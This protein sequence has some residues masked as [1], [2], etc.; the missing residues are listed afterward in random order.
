[1]KGGLAMLGMAPLTDTHG[2]K[3]LPEEDEESDSHD[4]E[5]VG[6]KVSNMRDVKEA[7]RG[8][9]FPAFSLFPKIFPLPMI[10]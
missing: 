8:A 9:T 4:R 3:V 6:E 1:M 7:P 5:G 10:P 2:S